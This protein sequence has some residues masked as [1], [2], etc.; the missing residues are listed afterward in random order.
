MLYHWQEAY[1]DGVRCIALDDTLVKGYLRISLAL[2]H[3]GKIKQAAAYVS[4]GLTLDNH[5]SALLQI[6]NEILEKHAGLFLQE[7]K[8][9]LSAK[10]FDKA[11]RALDTLSTLAGGSTHVLH[12]DVALQIDHMR[13]TINT[14]IRDQYMQPQE[15]SSKR[16]NEAQSGRSNS[17]SSVSS[18]RSHSRD[19]FQLDSVYNSEDIPAGLSPTNSHI[20]ERESSGS[21]VS[22]KRLLTRRSFMIHNADEEK[23]EHSN[24][25]KYEWVQPTVEKSALYRK[26]HIFEGGDAPLFSTRLSDNN[27]L[28]AGV[29]LYFIF[30]QYVSVLM[31]ACTVLAIP[32]IVFC[33]FGSGVLESQKDNL[34]LYR[35][36][37]GNF[38][39]NQNS[40]T[41]YTDS[42]CKHS[43]SGVQQSCVFINNMEIPLSTAC[44]VITACELAQL[45]LFFV[46]IILLQ[47]ECDQLDKDKSARSCSVT[48]YTIAVSNLPANCELEDLVAHFSSLYGL[49]STDWKHRLPVKNAFPVSPLP[50][51]ELADDDEWADVARR[52]L[53]QFEINP[54]LH[55]TW[56]ADIILHKKSNNLLS[57]LKRKEKYF[58]EFLQHRAQMQLYL[59]KGPPSKFKQSERAMLR[60]TKRFEGSKHKLSALIERMESGNSK[61]TPDSPLS[62]H[63]AD[64]MSQRISNGSPF[65]NALPGEVVMAFITFQY[66]ESFARCMEDYK[67]Y[68][69]FPWTLFYP[70]ELLF[71][72][73]VGQGD[74]PQAHKLKVT[75]APEPDEILWENLVSH[76]QM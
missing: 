3:L 18:G 72:P 65:Q 28:T 44:Y 52:G 19:S 36:T 1:D 27:D 51:S 71:R 17:G 48:D 42:Q 57:R 39:Y 38:G 5:S 63:S 47:V 73:R 50:E 9:H 26:I 11:S 69:G 31:F 25:L 49:D 64:S 35:V 70:A 62:E 37:I 75:Q 12:K 2:L 4:K 13:A 46:F 21:K 67:H 76:I 40:P 23:L 16:L 34:G 7:A 22:S 29:R 20:Y 32:T 30:L 33:F 10:D 41:Y 59:A 14:H 61:H 74:E 66:N 58:E 45:I 8:R 55:D 60:A 53:N 68:R 15:S 56:I 54:T 43:S 24:F 6:R